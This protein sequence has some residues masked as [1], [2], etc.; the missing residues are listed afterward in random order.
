M[1]MRRVKPLAEMTQEELIEQCMALMRECE[2]LRSELDTQPGSVERLIAEAEHHM[3]ECDS[4]DDLR[5]QVSH[6]KR[7]LDVSLRAAHTL[8]R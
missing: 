5:M 4:T 1:N 8:Q 6:L 3:R 2:E 7:A